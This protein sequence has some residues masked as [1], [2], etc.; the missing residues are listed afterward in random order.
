MRSVIIMDDARLKDVPRSPIVNGV[1]R[2]VYRNVDALLLPAHSHFADY[3]FWGVKDER[4]F[5]GV[6]AV[7]NAYFTK[8]SMHARRNA[9]AIRKTY[10]LPKNFFLGVGRQ[11]A[12]K[13]WDM[14]ISAYDRSLPVGSDWGL[15]LVGEGPEKQKLRRIATNL[16]RNPIFLPFLDQEELCKI[17][18]LAACLVLPSRYGETWGLVVNEA[19]ACCLPVIVSSECGCASTLV[20]DGYNGWLCN[21]QDTEGLTVL[22]GRVMALSEKERR[23]MG[24]RSLD[25]VSNWGLECFCKGV[26]EAIAYCKQLPS[27]SYAKPVLDRLILKLWKGRYRPL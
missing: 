27:Q 23:M 18:G 6:N 13:N 22:L 9:D 10:G 25:I 8:K 11:I 4:L 3:N 21:P 24:G 20:Y 14:L 7:D 1:K 16:P 12:K 17:Y 15:V 26:W 19:M 5:V 2:I